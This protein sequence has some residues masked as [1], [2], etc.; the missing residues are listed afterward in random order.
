MKSEAE[1]VKL[2]SHLLEASGDG[3]ELHKAAKDGKIDEL[4][5]L[6]VSGTDPDIIDDNG[7]T[8]LHFA[9]WMNH[10]DC[11]TLL[12]NHGADP[13]IPEGEGWTALHDA[14]RREYTDIVSLFLSRL[15]G[16]GPAEADYFKPGLTGDGKFLRMLE[17]L[18][19]ESVRLDSIGICGKGLLEDA[20]DRGYTKSADFLRKAAG[21]R[22]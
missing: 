17:L 8:A 11:V 13:E 20:V 9:A 18:K 12:F 5:N 19:E 2:Q 4:R 22:D 7:T 10:P 15:N 16:T 6:L 3:A 1:I 21:A 14:V